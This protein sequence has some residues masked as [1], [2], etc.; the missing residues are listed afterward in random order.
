M[1]S[2]LFAN[3]PSM[4]FAFDSH[5]QRCVCVGVYEAESK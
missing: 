5:M 4:L 1:N 2:T 3:E